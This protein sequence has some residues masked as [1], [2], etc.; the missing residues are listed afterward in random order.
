MNNLKFGDIIKLNQH[1][2]LLHQ[3]YWDENVISILKTGDIVVV[4]SPFV[5]CGFIS[6]LSS[7]GKI[8]WLYKDNFSKLT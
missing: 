1:K 3:P 7:H 2:T 5:E 6:V 8:G 4:V